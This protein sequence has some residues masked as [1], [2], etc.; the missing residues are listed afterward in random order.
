MLAPRD[1]RKQAGAAR[2]SL[3]RP[4]PLLTESVL[5]VALVGCSVWANLSF[6]VMNPFNFRYIPPFRAHGDYNRNSHLGAE[7]FNIGRALARGEGF[8]NPFGDATGP[9]A[10]QPPLYPAL[11]AGL[12]WT[13][14]GN[15][16]AV[17]AVV[18]VL[19]VLV[20]IGTGILV[21]LLIR[22][23]TR[24]AASVTALAFFLLVLCHF[25]L[26]F[27]LT[28]DSWLVML[29]LDGLLA[30]LCWARPLENWRRAAV[31]G[32][33][34]GVAG[35][36]SPVVGFTWAACSAL[37]AWRQ[38]HWSR[39]GVAALFAGLTLTPWAVRNYL[40]F[41]RWIPIKSNL[42]FEL[43]QS[44][45]QQK[46]GLLQNF[47]GHPAGAHRSEGQEYRKL[48][49]MAY[50][51]RK[52]EQYWQAVWADPEEFLDRIAARFIG[53][54]LWYVPFDPS[55]DARWSWV[56]WTNR[57]IYPLPFLAVLVLLLSAVWQR[58]SPAQG[59]GIAVYCFYLLPYIWASYYERYSLP[60]L[61]I[62]VILVLWAAERLLAWRRRDQDGTK[63]R[64]G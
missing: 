29:A 9:T 63:E 27:Q 4:F 19:Q 31:W 40:I 38:R 36:V 41:G 16:N 52:R 39:L 43:Y 7:Y 55:R 13:F 47:Q 50:L 11:L 15:R 6:A 14:A 32:L 57:L 8:A 12:L 49:E 10:W 42:A 48:G 59:F 2:R 20:L 17:M 54:T 21:L 62:K 51:D 25:W 26:C 35:L 45:C 18:I 28:H 1:I 61:G 33:F 64:I 58:L 53:A 37:A 46:E 30:G 23:T 34:G 22:S 44:H 56:L 60:L 3:R 24:L 5:A